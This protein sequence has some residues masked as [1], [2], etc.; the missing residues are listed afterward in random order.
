MN[1]PG[2]LGVTTVL[3][4]PC[5]VL[6]GEGMILPDGVGTDRRG[7]RVEALPVPLVLDD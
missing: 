2:V 3:T 7:G 1:E 5:S 6:A 4:E